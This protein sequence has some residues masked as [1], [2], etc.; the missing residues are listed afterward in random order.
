MVRDEALASMQGGQPF[1]G[2]IEVRMQI[3]VPIPSSYNK[4]KAEA[5]RLGKMYP[6]VTADIDNVCKSVLDAMNGV[7]FEDDSQ[8][9]DAH[10]TKRY[11]DEPCVICIITELP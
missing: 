11:A 3:F 6:T 2:A 10:L 9:V 5:C 8:V 4:A 7:V 1:T